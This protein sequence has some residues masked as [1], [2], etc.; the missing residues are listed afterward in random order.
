MARMARPL[1]KAEQAATQSPVTE[2]TATHSEQNGNSLTLGA[3]LA[4]W[5][6]HLQASDRIGSQRTIDA[7]MYGI[8]FL[9]DSVGSHRLLA[10]VTAEAIEALLGSLKRAGKSAGGRAVVFRPIRTFFR[11]CVARDLLDRSPAEKVAAPKA[12]VAPV[13]FVTDAEFAA[14]LK[15]TEH[16]TRWAFR[17]RRDRAIL[18]MLATTGARL[19]EVTNLRVS[20][21][22]MKAATFEVVGK[23]G[24]V[25]VL[26]L[27]PE[28]AEALRALPDARTAPQPVQ[29]PRGPVAGSWRAADL[30]RAGRHGRRACEG[31]WCAASRPSARTAPPGHR[32][33][34]AG[35]HA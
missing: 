34:A 12:P 23:R 8:G 25:R 9:A 17:A 30:E 14:I 35:G 18:L 5:H 3:A 32:L 2:Q 21:V 19:S 1:T 16:R 31:G 33:V 28:A 29:R 4:R 7:Y 10:Q 11:W 20:D 22:D 24:K 6:T 13:E 26:P 15:T 27:L